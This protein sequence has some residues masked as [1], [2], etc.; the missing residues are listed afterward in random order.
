M[1]LLVIPMTYTYSSDINYIIIALISH[2]KRIVLDS[3]LD[4]T[5]FTTSLIFTSWQF[6]AAKLFLLKSFYHVC[7][8]GA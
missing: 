1:T 8:V 3:E 4:F 5:K 2:W 6:S 7:M